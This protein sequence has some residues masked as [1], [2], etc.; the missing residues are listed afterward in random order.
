VALQGVGAEDLL[1]SGNGRWW[2]Q[3]HTEGRERVSEIEQ[4]LDRSREGG[5]GGRW[6]HNSTRP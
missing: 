4:C 2:R 6:R 3:Q 5:G 1:F